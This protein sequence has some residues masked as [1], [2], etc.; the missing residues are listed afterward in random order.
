MGWWLK[1]KVGLA[2]GFMLVVAASCEGT[3]SEGAEQGEGG[4]GAGGAP[5]DPFQVP[6]EI[7][8]LAEYCADRS[9][10]ESPDDVQPV[11]SARARTTRSD[12]DCDGTVVSIQ[13]GLGWT[14]YYFDATGALMG[15]HTTSDKGTECADGHTTLVRQ[16]GEICA[17]VGTSED[18]CPAPCNTDVA[19]EN[20][21]VSV[22]DCP[23]DLA[24]FEPLCKSGAFTAQYE[25]SCGG[26]IIEVGAVAHVQTFTF[27]ESGALVG[28]VLLGDVG[29]RS[30][31]GVPCEPTGERDLLC[32][33]DGGGGGGEG[34]DA[35]SGGAGGAPNP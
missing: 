8:D 29:D 1:A 18:L 10:P 33:G 27:D 15:I 17:F 3:S 25:S 9:C 12:T 13:R 6:C 24:S 5:P 11:C 32:I 21:G 30:C 35:G 4:A 2:C 7:G 22:V 16:Q 34:G 23:E 20:V 31:W 28:T 26:T 14:S 19:C